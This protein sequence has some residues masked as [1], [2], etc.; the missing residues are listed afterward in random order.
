ME[1]VSNVLLKFCV[2]LMPGVLGELLVSRETGQLTSRVSDGL[3]MVSDVQLIS[4]SDEL[5]M[6]SVGLL[7]SGVLPMPCGCTSAGATQ[8]VPVEMVDLLSYVERRV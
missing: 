6:M 3:L 5:L 2:L 7:I 8:L 1:L 4:S